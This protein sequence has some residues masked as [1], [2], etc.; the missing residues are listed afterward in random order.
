MR[1]N[2]K[3]KN[4]FRKEKYWFKA[5]ALSV[6][7]CFTLNNIAFAIGPGAARTQADTL[8][9]VS[10]LDPMVNIEERDGV[11]RL[12]LTKDGKAV[13][14]QDFQ[15]EWGFFYLTVYIGEILKNYG[16]KI[17]ASK[18]KKELAKHL[19]HVEFKRFNWKRIRKEGKTFCL[20]YT[21][22]SGKRRVKPFLRFYLE[23]EGPREAR[24]KVSMPINDSV[25]MTC[26]YYTLTEM[27]SKRLEDEIIADNIVRVKTGRNTSIEC[28]IDTLGAVIE[29]DMAVNIYPTR[30]ALQENRELQKYLYGEPH[31]ILVSAQTFGRIT[32][33]II[34]IGDKP[35]LLIEEVQSSYGFRKMIAADKKYIRKYCQWKNTLI[36]HV[37]TLAGRIGIE[38]VYA[39]TPERITEIID[40]N[41]DS[42]RERIIDADRLLEKYS[43][44]QTQIHHHYRDPFAKEWERVNLSSYSVAGLEKREKH[45]LWHRKTAAAEEEPAEEE[46]EEVEQFDTSGKVDDS[47]KEAQ[48]TFAGS[49]A[50]LDK[51]TIKVAI[52]L[53][54]IYLAFNFAPQ[55]ALYKILT[56][57]LPAVFLSILLHEGFHWGR[58]LLLKRQKHKIRYRPVISKEGVYFDLFTDRA[59]SA[60]KILEAGPEGSGLVST[61]CSL[62]TLAYSPSFLMVMGIVNMVLAASSRDRA[63]LKKRIDFIEAH[64]EFYKK[65]KKVKRSKKFKEAKKPLL[66]LLGGYFASGKGLLAS[67]LES[68]LEKKTKSRVHIIGGDNWLWREAK[69]SR[70]ITYPYDKYEID[71]WKD[72]VKRLKEGKTAYIPY[73]LSMFGRRLNVRQKDLDELKSSMSVFQKSGYN[74]LHA[75][76]MRKMPIGDFFPD[77]YLSAMFAKVLK[78]WENEPETRREIIDLLR[79]TLKKPVEDFLIDRKSKLCIDADTGDILEA[80]TP[81]EGDILMVEFEQAL[82]DEEIRNSADIRGFVEASPLHRRDYFMSRRKSGKRYS[83]LT[84]EQTEE[85]F[86]MLFTQEENLLEQ[87]EYADIIVQNDVPL[88][89][90]VLDFADDEETLEEEERSP[91]NLKLELKNTDIEIFMDF[92][93]GAE[94][95]KE[96]LARNE[97]L[98]LRRFTD[99]FKELKRK[100]Q[101]Q[102]KVSMITFEDGATGMTFFV[103]VTN[104]SKEKDICEATIHALDHELS[105]LFGAPLLER[106]AKLTQIASVQA[107]KDKYAEKKG[108][109]IFDILLTLKRQGFQT[110][111]VY[112]NETKIVKSPRG[113]YHRNIENGEE[114]IYKHALD[115]NAIVQEIA[116]RYGFSREEKDHLQYLAHEVIANIIEFGEEGV[117]GIKPVEE[118]GGVIGLEI[119]AWDIGPGLDDPELMTRHSMENMPVRGGGFSRIRELVYQTIIETRRKIWVSNEGNAFEDGGESSVA[120]GTKINLVY[121]KAEEPKEKPRPSHEEIKT[122]GEITVLRRDAVPQHMVTLPV[123]NARDLTAEARRVAIKSLERW[124]ATGEVIHMPEIRRYM[125]FLEY[126]EEEELSFLYFV[127]SSDY[128]EIEGLA[129]LGSEGMS[130]SIMENAPWNREAAQ[131]SRRYR[132]VGRQ[133]RAFAI[134]KLIERYGID[135]YAA[136]NI[137]RIITLG[138]KEPQH[139][140]DVFDPRAI[141]REQIE[142]YLRKTDEEKQQFTSAYG[143]KDHAPELT[144]ISDVFNPQFLDKAPPDTISSTGYKN[145]FYQSLIKRMEKVGEMPSRLKPALK[146][147][148][149]LID[150][151]RELSLQE[152]STEILLEALNPNELSMDEHVDNIEAL[153]WLLL[154]EEYRE[155]ALGGLAR[156]PYDV[157]YTGGYLPEIESEMSSFPS[158]ERVENL[159]KERGEKPV[160]IYFMCRHRRDRSPLQYLVARKLLREA[161]DLPGVNIHARS[162]YDSIF[163]SMNPRGAQA[164]LLLGQPRED[165]DEVGSPLKFSEED[166]QQATIVIVTEDIYN[167]QLPVL[168]GIR[169]K[170]VNI[171]DFI[172][173]LGGA[174]NE[175]VETVSTED[176]GERYIDSYLLYELAFRRRLIP[177]L[178]DS[179]S[180]KKKTGYVRILPLILGAILTF[181]VVSLAAEVQGN[182]KS[183]EDI[184]IVNK[185]IK[186]RVELLKGSSKPRTE[187]HQEK[188]ENWWKTEENFQYMYKW[189]MSN[190]AGKTEEPP[191]DKDAVKK[192]EWWNR[193][194]ESTLDYYLEDYKERPRAFP[195][196]RK[197]LV[198]RGKSVVPQL[199]RRLLYAD[200]NI[201][202]AAALV[203]KD[204]N[205][206]ASEAVQKKIYEAKDKRNFQALAYYMNALEIIDPRNLV[207]LEAELEKKDIYAWQEVSHLRYWDK[208]RPTRYSGMSRGWFFATLATLIALVM[209]LEEE[210]KKI[211]EDFGRIVTLRP[212]YLR[213]IEEA[214]SYM[215]KKNRL[216]S[217]RIHLNPGSKTLMPLIETRYG[218]DYLYRGWARRALEEIGP[219][220]LFEE[221]ENAKQDSR[222][223][224]AALVEKHLKLYFR[225]AFARRRVWQFI[226]ELASFREKPVEVIKVKLAPFEGP[227]LGAKSKDQAGS[228]QDENRGEKN[229]GTLKQTLVKHL[230]IIIALGFIPVAILLFMVE[231]Q[232]PLLSYGLLG[233][234]FLGVLT[235]EN[236]GKFIEIDGVSYEVDS[237]AYRELHDK[238]QTVPDSTV[239][240]G[241]GDRIFWIKVNDFIFPVLAVRSE[242]ETFKLYII[243]NMSQ[244][245]IDD[246]ITSLGEYPA[247]Q[248]AWRKCGNKYLY[249][250]FS[251]GYDLH[252]IGRT[253]EMRGSKVLFEE[254]MTTNADFSKTLEVLKNLIILNIENLSLDKILDENIK[255]LGKTFLP[256]SFVYKDENGNYSILLLAKG[257]ERAIIP[258]FIEC[259]KGGMGYR[260]STMTAITYMNHR[261]LE[262]IVSHISKDEKGKYWR[263]YAEQCVKRWSDIRELIRE[264]LSETELTPYSQQL[265]D[266]VSCYL[267]GYEPVFVRIL[268][269]LAESAKTPEEA[270]S[271]I[272]DLEFSEKKEHDEIAKDILRLAY[273]KGGIRGENDTR[274]K[275]KPPRKIILRK[276]K[277]PGK[278]APAEL[279]EV[280]KNKKNRKLLRKALGEEG[281]A[282]G[283][284]LR[285]RKPYSK[286]TVRREFKTLTALGIFIEI[287]EQP[288][289]YR[290]SPIVEGFSFEYIR[291]FIDEVNSIERQ[292]GKRGEKRP[293]WRGEIPLERIPDVK[294]DIEEVVNELR[295]RNKERLRRKLKGALNKAVG[296]LVM[297][298]CG[299]RTERIDANDVWRIGGYINKLGFGRASRDF[300]Q[301]CIIL[302]EMMESE[303]VVSDL[304]LCR[305][306]EEFAYAPYY[307]L[308]DIKVDEQR[309]RNLARQAFTWALKNKHPVLRRKIRFGEVGN[310]TVREFIEF[311][312]TSLDEKRERL[313]G[314]LEI[315][316]ESHRR[317]E[318]EEAI[319]EAEKTLAMLENSMVYYVQD[320]QK[321][322]RLFIDNTLAT[323]GTKRVVF[324]A[325]QRLGGLASAR[326]IARTT[327][328]PLEMVLYDL[329]ILYYFDLVDKDGEG[330]LAIFESGDLTPSEKKG[331]EGVLRLL[332]PTLTKAEK[333][334]AKKLLREKTK[335]KTFFGAPGGRLNL[336][337]GS[338]TSSIALAYLSSFKELSPLQTAITLVIFVAVPYTLLFILKKAIKLARGRERKDNDIKESERTQKIQNKNSIQD[339]NEVLYDGYEGGVVRGEIIFD[340]TVSEYLRAD[341][342]CI[343]LGKVAKRVCDYKV[344]GAMISYFAK[345]AVHNAL[346]HASMKGKR[347]DPDKK[348]VLRYEINREKVKLMIDDEGEEEFSPEPYLNMG[349]WE[350]LW[351]TVKSIPKVIMIW[352]APD[353]KLPLM[354]RE[355]GFHTAI[356]KMGRFFD[357]VKYYAHY[358]DGKKT[359]GTF[360]LIYNSRTYVKKED[361]SDTKEPEKT[362]EKELEEKET[363]PQEEASPTAI[364]VKEILLDTENRPEP[365]EA[366]SFTWEEIKAGIRL[367]FGNEIEDVD[368]FIHSVENSV[369]FK[370]ELYNVLPYVET[371]VSNVLREFPDHK[372]LVVARDGEVFYDALKTILSH[373]PREDEISLF[374]GSESFMSYL[375]NCHDRTF[376]L[377]YYTHPMEFLDD[378]GI[379]PEAIKNG[380]KFLILDTG[381]RGSIG[382]RLKEL[383]LK[384]FRFQV[385][386]SEVEEAVKIG[387]MASWDP[388]IATSVYADPLVNFFLEEDD[389]QK[390]FPKSIKHI[391]PQYRQRRGYYTNIV[392]ATALQLLPRY[393]EEF[394]ALERN[395]NGKLVPVTRNRQA[396]ERDIDEASSFNSSIVNPVAALLVQR[397]VIGYFKRSEAYRSL[398]NRAFGE[399]IE[400]FREKKPLPIKITGLARTQRGDISGFKVVYKGIAGFIP[401]GYTPVD[402]SQGEE[403]LKIFMGG[404]YE[405]YVTDPRDYR[406]GDHTVFSVLPDKGTKARPRKGTSPKQRK[407]GRT[408]RLSKKFLRQRTEEEELF[409]METEHIDGAHVL[410]LDETIITDNKLRILS[411]KDSL[412]N[413]WEEYVYGDIVITVKLRNIIT[414]E[415]NI[416][417]KFF[418][419]EGS[420]KGKILVGRKEAGSIL[421]SF[422]GHWLEVM[423]SAQYLGPGVAETMMNWAAKRAKRDEKPLEINI[424]DSPLAIRRIAAQL[425]GNLQEGDPD[426][427]KAIDQSVFTGEASP[428]NP[429]L[430][431]EGEVAFDFWE[432]FQ[433]IEM[434]GEE[435]SEPPDGSPHEIFKKLQKA[436]NYDYRRRVGIYG[437]GAP[438]GKMAELLK[439][440]VGY[441]SV[442]EV[443]RET[444]GKMKDGHLSSG[445]VKRDLETLVYLDL[446]EKEGEGEKATYNDVE[447][448]YVEEQAALSVLRALG[449]RPTSK[450][451]KEAKRLLF[452]KRLK[453]LQGKGRGISLYAAVNG[454]NI[455]IKLSG[456][457]H[458]RV[459]VKGA[460]A[461]KG[462]IKNEEMML[463]PDVKSS[464]KDLSK[465]SR[466]EILNSLV[467]L[468]KFLSESGLN[469]MKIDRISRDNLEKLGMMGSLPENIGQLAKKQLTE[470]VFGGLSGG[471]NLSHVTSRARPYL[472]KDVKTAEDLL[473]RLP[474]AVVELL[475]RGR[476]NQLIACEQLLGENEEGSASMEKQPE[477]AKEPQEKEIRTEWNVYIDPSVAG[478]ASCNLSVYSNQEKVGH[479]NLQV[480][481]RAI[482][483]YSCSGINL[484]GVPRKYRKGIFEEALM[485]AQEVAQQRGMTP[486]WVYVYYTLSEVEARNRVRPLSGFLKKLG[487][488]DRID[489]KVRR[490]PSYGQLHGLISEKNT[491]YGSGQ[492]GYWFLKLEKEK[493]LMALP[494][495]AAPSQAAAVEEIKK[496]KA[497]RV[498]NIKVI[499]HIAP[500]GREETFSVEEALEAGLIKEGRL[501]FEDGKFH[502]Y[503]EEKGQ[504]VPARQGDIDIAQVST[505][506]FYM[507]EEPIEDEGDEEV[508]SFEEETI[509][510]PLDVYERLVR[511][512]DSMDK[513]GYRPRIGHVDIPGSL[514][515]ESCRLFRT[516]KVKIACF[517]VEAHIDED[518]NTYEALD[519]EYVFDISNGEDVIGHGIVYRAPKSGKIRF[520]YSIHGGPMVT[521]TQ[522]GIDYHGKGYGK[523]ALK[524][525]MA[526]SIRGGLFKGP[527]ETFSYSVHPDDR[528]TLFGKDGLRKIQRILENAG[529]DENLDYDVNSRTSQAKMPSEGK[530]PLSRWPLEARGRAEKNPYGRETYVDRGFNS[531]NFRYGNDIEPTIQQKISFSSGRPVKILLYAVGRGFEAFDLM[532]RYGDQ[533]DI[534]ATSKEDLLYRTPEEVVKRFDEEGK[535]S[536]SIEEAEEMITRLRKQYSQCDLDEDRIFGDESF[537]IVIFG[538][539]VML[540]I[541]RK[542]PALEEALRVCKTDGVVYCDL[543]TT[544]GMEEGYEGHLAQLLMKHNDGNI[545]CLDEREKGALRI[546]KEP[547]LEMPRLRETGT[548]TRTRDG[549]VGNEV[550]EWETFYEIEEKNPNVTC[551]TICETEHRGT[552]DSLNRQLAVF[553]EGLAQEAGLE[554]NL[555]TSPLTSNEIIKALSETRGYDQGMLE[556]IRA[557]IW[558]HIPEIKKGQ[559]QVSFAIPPD[560][561][562]LWWVEDKYA[563]GH[564][565]KKRLHISLPLILSKDDPKEAALDVARHDYNHI[566]GKGHLGDRGMM[567]VVQASGE[568]AEETAPEEEEID[569]DELMKEIERLGAILEKEVSEIEEAFEKLEKWKEL[570]EED[571]ENLTIIKKKAKAISRKIINPEANSGFPDILM[572]SLITGDVFSVFDVRNI[573]T[574]LM[575]AADECFEDGTVSTGPYDAARKSLLHLKM[576]VKALKTAKKE[577]LMIFQW[578]GGYGARNYVGFRDWDSM[579]PENSREWMAYLVAYHRSIYESVRSN[580]KAKKYFDEYIEDVIRLRELVRAGEIDTSREEEKDMWVYLPEY[581]HQVDPDL[582]YKLGEFARKKLKES[583]QKKDADRFYS[584]ARKLLVRED[585]KRVNI[586]EGHYPHLDRVFGVSDFSELEGKDILVLGCGGGTLCFKA[587]RSGANRVVGVDSDGNSITLANMLAP[588][589]NDPEFTDIMQEFLVDAKRLFN[590]MKKD[591]PEF[592]ERMR[593]LRFLRADARDLSMLDDNSF[594][595]VVIPYLF[596]HENGLIFEDDMGRVLREAQRVTKVGGKVSVYPFT[597]GNSLNIYQPLGGINAVVKRFCEEGIDGK[598][599]VPEEKL[600]REGEYRG[601]FRIE[602]I[603][604][605]ALEAEE[606]PQKE[607]EMVQK[608]IDSIIGWVEARALS[609]GVRGEKLI[610]GINTGWIPE[611]QLDSAEVWKLLKRIERLSEGKLKGFKNIEVCMASSP[612]VLASE[613]WNARKTKGTSAPLTP[614]SNVILLGEEEVFET[615]SFR[616]FKGSDTEEGAFFA[617]LRLPERFEGKVP[618]YTDINMIRLITKVLDMASSPHCKKEFYVDLPDVVKESLQE[619]VEEYMKREDVLTKA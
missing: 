264:G 10:R 106:T 459:G 286:E 92:M 39:S 20:P 287:N 62:L 25:S 322:M 43:Y 488:T 586:G 416:V 462:F 356:N 65:V 64:R 217:E 5:I 577:K 360:T 412:R 154:E 84:K 56:D 19:S 308:T 504:Q 526:A 539:A 51:K 85:K 394:R 447:L 240:I 430:T 124:L 510:G 193:V 272:D 439:K 78:V 564:F 523:E 291:R 321:K 389:L 463:I 373:L 44:S 153:M 580:D 474:P 618:E 143:F 76:Y 565:S 482:V 218:E 502:L 206:A 121:M 307:D 495:D 538:R 334:R 599:F 8:S 438:K 311:F 241:E 252:Q 158:K 479:I 310:I 407:R 230:H 344:E 38:D 45:Q 567:M 336:S 316:R 242:E 461:F 294:K 574:P 245:I 216:F 605:E 278:G 58:I 127:F 31:H 326:E 196:H 540:Y 204:M 2:K 598:K 115:A 90:K 402:F 250:D 419:E 497:K 205:P 379:T 46:S 77:R 256:S 423:M 267:Q 16:S 112:D 27:Y 75:D 126:N 268:E 525:L 229:S 26:E 468:A 257:A 397:K 227:V 282:P 415:N 433:I 40:K 480:E 509:T 225:S 545:E 96:I 238:Y 401:K 7:L 446:A 179:A 550:P 533:I 231:N 489:E 215:N 132:G 363:L 72:A 234:A 29:E 123:V 595:L 24:A 391:A 590:L 371:V 451:K 13:P 133:L 619:L 329:D 262:K 71:R 319:A 315:I 537:D 210:W 409:R 57:V 184:D 396:I 28:E 548:M 597:K 285:Y 420:E 456:V 275:A 581:E 243:K 125:D 88:E 568:E 392:M 232:N 393:Q 220:P 303:R 12:V 290:F 277:A 505:A 418:S 175:K 274:K 490:D 556:G 22:S 486:A 606:S 534:T 584:F 377:D 350:V 487:F 421:Y 263:E 34:F 491:M 162:A 226:R 35:A 608:F 610:I 427:F 102:R 351:C 110:L 166:A 506:G 617:K 374:P 611:V 385:E 255:K 100:T 178:A 141:N 342:R 183:D 515:W 457:E 50:F 297:N 30:E 352:T 557:H 171:A 120:N 3:M 212:K 170:V 54:I 185:W 441:V 357:S 473:E 445:T 528:R 265:F 507:E 573:C 176:A 188:L 410:D 503:A 323:I 372:V 151:L 549:L 589:M 288:G 280:L 194:S 520:R 443:R 501:H 587:L 207:K 562:K 529:F 485:R 359:G 340:C 66:I 131:E 467:K 328:L 199:V 306:S 320:T 413:V 476:K 440:K 384:V 202:Q 173:D 513:S 555:V 86:K 313:N 475:P 1:L 292:V 436:S 208:Y 266:T 117:F 492:F 152:A 343:P 181:S 431:N 337:F 544:F 522:E 386:K 434:E 52:L 519:E 378:I 42:D 333:V 168:E 554:K 593:D 254:E 496:L 469:N 276:K 61:I 190:K 146:R 472:T 312:F 15:E 369:T 213:T 338:F 536:V 339:I 161:G 59:S 354:R 180:R 164:A 358:E 134:R 435:V 382:H 14:T 442:E 17:S 449:D 518:A 122:S 478:G 512:A 429:C 601:L 91:E 579:P 335:N 408:N 362:K 223:E 258:V 6:I 578:D 471:M 83:K 592:L 48:V 137:S 69:R 236:R 74:L 541:H 191:E 381:F 192:D 450:E 107:I 454:K 404:K 527:V 498:K 23:E 177:L 422:D 428:L 144:T 273:D 542:Y 37:V 348:V 197:N 612:S 55:V 395:E 138:H 118:N 247:A 89:K 222:K 136:E 221:L 98:I 169:N 426:A 365:E 233:A 483:I 477:E 341:I 530:D 299:Q 387:I 327:N 70:E 390:M 293:L 403:D 140:R 591:K 128:T 163:T 305:D 200:G 81:L 259:T 157:L 615:E 347:L 444:R 607:E 613:V 201:R 113:I 93:P 228:E 614:L 130:H 18:L 594:D 484:L 139:S 4:C 383:L 448:G 63:Q 95:L 67:N 535:F 432:G 97:E 111:L 214:A 532:A 301:M 87:K 406:V 129:D 571:E 575:M 105:T 561:R 553:Y 103:Q 174:F 325:L 239:N 33:N 60:R 494:E 209:V 296:D 455:K 411:V 21:P 145:G 101:K 558:E 203:L 298:L 563:G 82:E 349:F 283:E 314:L 375:E 511:L 400:A 41:H 260:I 261:A 547:D 583:A 376:G 284:L 345:E 281:I 399:I 109:S 155:Y 156:T 368:S 346:V 99:L 570:E 521:M 353:E 53:P 465:V 516:D 499:N 79:E 388:A 572:R 460:I 609:T 108:Q 269:R 543:S 367:A 466:K 458:P 195:L 309:T 585:G 317:K 366:A 224:D 148:K 150:G 370:Q 552:I 470:K 332:P 576:I 560:G 251:L 9:P 142:E 616:R 604:K 355:Y 531:L 116:Q 364:R 514:D 517:K 244:E 582:M 569:R 271:N 186:E 524:L 453:I 246:F 500:Y 47:V 49:R 219:K 380:E 405:A 182:N 318:R 235:E 68:Y 147:M 398:R 566:S 94:E 600:L 302:A 198:S 596:N 414:G 289:H 304:A 253:L 167:S 211:V 331:I 189:M 602:S 603:E 73:Y 80:F 588:Y 159:I 172:S 279:L 165:I 270:F 324:N 417:I 425:T 36:E 248:E 464:S 330:E 114:H 135:I 104:Y 551:G 481:P 160:N 452:R 32:L 493:D 249:T 187:V 424:G 149:E 437:F 295:M 237:K 300:G 559:I 361:I 11:L 508:I 119:A 546:K